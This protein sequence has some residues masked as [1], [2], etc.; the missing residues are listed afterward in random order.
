MPLTRNEI[1]L[2]A[3]TKLDKKDESDILRNDCDIIEFML[4]NCEITIPKES[5]FFVKVNC[6]GIMDIIISKRAKRFDAEIEDGEF[7]EGIKSM[8]YSGRYDISHT[9]ADWERVI[10][11]GIVGLRGA[12][13]EYYVKSDKSEKS[14]RFFENLKRIY[15]AAIRFMHR[16]SKTAEECGRMQMAQGL[17]N[18]TKNAP[19]NLFEALQTS[20]VYYALQH[21]FEGTYLRTL[22]RVDSL[23]YPFYLNED[24]GNAKALIE[25]Y[26]YEIDKLDAPS[27]IPFALG[28]TDIN[29]NSLANELT[30][31][32]LDAYK[33]ID[34]SNTKLHILYS[35][36]MNE[37]VL[38][39]AFR[40]VV[41][42][43]NSIVFMSDKRIIESLIN[44]GAER[45][46]ATNY[47][48]V[49]CY[50]CGANNEI[51]CSCNAKVNIPKA[52]ELAING[53][54]DMITGKLIGKEN[55]PNFKTYEELYFEFGRQLEYMCECAI[56]ITDFYEKEYINIHS[57][58]FL[59]ST[60]TSSLNNA[61]DIYCDNSAKYT[62]SS[63]NAVGLAT[64]VDS[65]EAI[66][67]IV[68]EDK[69][70]TISE[71]TEILKNNW[72][73]EDVLRHT[74]KNK[75]DKFGTGEKRTDDMAQDISAFVI[76]L[77]S[78]RP[79]VKGGKYRVGFFSIDW[80]WELGE[81]TAASADGRLSGETLSQNTSA[82]FGTDKKGATAHLL[83]VTKIDTSQTPN[84]V[85][86][87]IDLHKSSVQGENGINALVS[88]L[89]TYFKLG[90]FSV[91]YNVLDTDILMKAKKNPKEY[92]NLQVR[93]CGWNVLFSTLTEKE[94][95]EF[96]ERSVK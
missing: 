17:L 70:H 79:N 33:K 14:K 3:E 84:G 10:S 55:E 65:L 11:L 82:T 43:N 93:L 38:N 50:E 4:D 6:A 2:F 23:Y 76:N 86:V 68:F 39:E 71:L 51:T 52:L 7:K 90:G 57:A 72:Q 49:G 59:S 66:R 41:D 91:Q 40:G 34:T 74:A 53:G 42:G 31:V 29:G 46:D 25:S 67:K 28:G 58:P 24:K 37:D 15:D 27:N 61:G 87:D 35:D 77:V 1:L 12:L 5:T 36:N 19:S 80:R 30:Y 48:V 63:L 75:F 95:D 18:L 69:T 78:G 20:I 81:K 60:Y 83:S 8:A 13:D 21:M 89:K 62:N 45:S 9:N 44:I 47:H 94:K 85:I 32:F 64:A 92:P 96:I 26:I 54:R 56:K 22:G 16:C 73:M 88:T